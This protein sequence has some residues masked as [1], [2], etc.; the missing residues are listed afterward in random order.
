MSIE[1]ENKMQTTPGWTK[2]LPCIRCGTN[3]GLPYFYDGK[4][5]YTCHSCGKEYG[6]I[7]DENSYAVA[8]TN[9]CDYY[10]YNKKGEIEIR[11]FMN[12]PL[13]WLEEAWQ[14][15]QGLNNTEKNPQILLPIAKKYHDAIKGR[16]RR[17]LEVFSGSL[18]T[19]ETQFIKNDN[20]KGKS[21]NIKNLFEY[22]K[23]AYPSKKSQIEEFYLLNNS[24]INRVW[25]IRNKQEH[26]LFSQW[27][28]NSK[29]F[30]DLS[31]NPGD[32]DIAPDNLNTDFI[33]RVNNLS[34]D[35]YKLIIDLKPDSEDQWYDDE[36]E[37]FRYKQS[38][39]NV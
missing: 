36:L 18:T 3:L 17:F 11:C 26:I 6:T 22:L 5:K 35:V 4:P 12:P 34:V 24:L 20:S 8:L 9:S 23:T 13:D 32:S 10:R 7:Q 1:E 25:W 15:S 16:I 29:I 2:S 14:D 21:L 19:E 27:P 39:D 33:K 31:K 28:M 37:R 38:D 30:E